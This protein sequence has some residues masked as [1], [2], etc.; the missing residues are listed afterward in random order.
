MSDFK[1]K[2]AN[3][4]TKETIKAQIRKYNNGKKA[5]KYGVCQYLTPE[6]NRCAIGCFIPSGHIALESKKSVKGVL[7]DYPELKDKMPFDD[8]SGL[9]NFQG[10]HDS[11]IN[12]ID[13]LS[14][15]PTIEKWIDQHVEDAT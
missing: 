4:W 2:T 9:R 10:A 1:Y 14:V 11:H 13:G 6:G 5:E 12:Q 15:Y 3:G 8:I 7:E